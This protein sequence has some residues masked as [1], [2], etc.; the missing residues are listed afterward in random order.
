[1]VSGNNLGDGLLWNKFF[2]QA[3]EK[4]PQHDKGQGLINNGRENQDQGFVIHVVSYSR[5]LKQEQIKASGRS[6]QVISPQRLLTVA[7]WRW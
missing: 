1:M 4:H 2:E 6:S 3:G 7:S 5:W